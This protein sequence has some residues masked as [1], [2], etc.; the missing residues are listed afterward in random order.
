VTIPLV[1]L[2]RAQF[3]ALLEESREVVLAF[4]LS[5][6]TLEDSDVRTPVCRE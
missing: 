6:L 2:R 5:F 1:P 3:A 4:R